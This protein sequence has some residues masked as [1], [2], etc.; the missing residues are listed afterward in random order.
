MVGEH[1]A[2]H[3]KKLILILFACVTL[4]LV[5]MIVVRV[6]H[7]V[8]PVNH[9]DLTIP[10]AE[11]A[12]QSEVLNSTQIIDSVASYRSGSYYGLHVLVDKSATFVPVEVFPTN[13]SNLT[14][15]NLVPT[16]NLECF[17]L[18]EKPNVRD[19]YEQYKRGDLV[20]YEAGSINLDGSSTPIFSLVVET[21]DKKR[22]RVD[23]IPV[24]GKCSHLV[25]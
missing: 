18:G 3:S 21:K 16:S 1:R 17:R 2:S 15:N 7:G 22:F 6:R 24:T 11:K 19:P 13:T 12:L 20:A 4:S 8:Q 25:E 10:Y 5:A 23:G 9:I 14:S